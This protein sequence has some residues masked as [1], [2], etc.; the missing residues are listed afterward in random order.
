M[1]I[2]VNKESEIVVEIEQQTWSYLDLCAKY[3]I[4]PSVLG[5]A[6]HLEESYE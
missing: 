1:K 6:R 3:E 2:P 4:A 5:F